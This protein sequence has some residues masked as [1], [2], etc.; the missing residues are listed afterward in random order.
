MLHNVSRMTRQRRVI[1]EALRNT[2]S[3]PTADEIYAV[4]RARMPHISLGTVYR[5]LDFL[6]DSGEILKLEAAGSTRRFDGIT[7]PHRHIRCTG[8]GRVADVAIVT[9]E[10]DPAAVQ[11]EGFTVTGARIEYEGLCDACRQQ[12]SPAGPSTIQEKNA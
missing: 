8:C 3:H 7:A 9:P 12:A 10:P 2:H 5:N 4:V 6:A 1:L 11:V